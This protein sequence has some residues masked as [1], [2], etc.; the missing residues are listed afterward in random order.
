MASS[1]VRRNLSGE[2]GLTG[3]NIQ[4]TLAVPALQELG[5]LDVAD[6]SDIGLVH[7]AKQPPCTPGIG[8]RGC[9]A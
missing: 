5:P 8:I 7:D 2:S 4:E 6:H 1:P 9:S 3:L